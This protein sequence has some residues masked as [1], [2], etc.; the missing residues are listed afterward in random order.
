M[1]EPSPAARLV[2]ACARVHPGASERDR[3]AEALRQPIDWD[4]VA[5]LATR[6]G[7]AALLH[8][9]LG[10]LPGVPKRVGAML[11]AR[12]ETV[13]RRNEAM[14]AELCRVLGALEAGGV[15]A[16]PFKGPVLTLDLYGELGLREFGDLDLL[17]MPGDLTRAV[18]LLAPLG[19]LPQHALAAH[20]EEAWMASPRAH[21]MALLDERR[22]FMVE[23]QWSANPG[24]AIPRVADRD[25]W[26]RLER[27]PF[28]GH[29]TNVL[30]A[31]E[32]AIALLVHGSKHA[33]ANLGW[34]VDIAE[35]ARSGRTD[36]EWLLAT[37]RAERAV[38][39][40]A[41]GLDLARRLLDAPVPDVALALIEEARVSSI[42]N[43]IVPS[44]LAP[45]FTGRPI[46]ASQRIQVALLD[47]PAQR[48]RYLAMLAFAPA[49]GDLQRWRLPPGLFFLY[50]LLRPLRLAEAHLFSP[51]SPRIPTGASPRTPPPQPHST[52]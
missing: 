29:E 35:L 44:I 11:W 20:L 46:A 39:R 7:L 23:L 4:E 45:E 12:A 30:S 50:W 42:T 19:Y 21:E 16:V 25:W 14:S 8:R 1:T 32:N 47:T 36:W 9:N 38:R 48:W 13:A 40:V 17:V 15:D 37:A 26:R 31:R 5:A 3:I 51:R 6:H 28:F 43:A 34:L 10:E 24:F 41:L 33:W 52:N 18:H 49:L 2:L 27:R 22:G